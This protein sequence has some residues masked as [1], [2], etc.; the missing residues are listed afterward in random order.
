MALAQEMLK[1]AKC[2]QNVMLSDE[3]VEFIQQSDFQ[4]KT[5]NDA[6]AIYCGG[7]ISHCHDGTGK[8]HDELAS[9]LRGKLKLKILQLVQEKITK[10]SSLELGDQIQKLGQ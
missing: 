8:L 7:I 6:S 4:L 3:H 2:I 5:L 9:I 1:G 10:K